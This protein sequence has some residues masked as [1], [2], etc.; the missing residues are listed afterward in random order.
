MADRKL[1]ATLLDMRR[2]QKL[3]DRKDEPVDVPEDP[4][5]ERNTPVT[6]LAMALGNQPTQYR[7]GMDEPEEDEDEMPKSRIQQLSDALRSRAQA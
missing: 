7:V 6:E 5:M 3:R 4:P 2:T 1:G